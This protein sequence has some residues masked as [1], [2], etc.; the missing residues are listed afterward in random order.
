MAF[1]QPRVPKYHGR[2]EEKAYLRTLVLFLTDFCMDVWTAYRAQQ[3]AMDRLTQ[4]MDEM[5]SKGM[6]TDAAV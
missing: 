6:N 5:E 4:R 1:K 2:E 3:Q